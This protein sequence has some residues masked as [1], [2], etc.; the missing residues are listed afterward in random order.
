M[1]QI[2]CDDKKCSLQPSRHNQFGGGG[3]NIIVGSSGGLAPQ[4]GSYLIPVNDIQERKRR[5][6][7]KKKP[8]QFGGKKKK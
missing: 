4:A 8:I 1:R 7:P 6:I 5:S 3:D 2:V